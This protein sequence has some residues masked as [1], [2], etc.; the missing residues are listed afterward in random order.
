MFCFLE[1][2]LRGADGTVAGLRVADGNHPLQA[3]ELMAV[4]AEQP[5]QEFDAKALHGF[6]PYYNFIYHDT[7]RP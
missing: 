6:P 5:V 7:T 4:R 2:A 1:T 3:F